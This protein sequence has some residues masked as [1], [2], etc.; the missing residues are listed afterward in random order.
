MENQ[1]TTSTVEEQLEALD[2][3]LAEKQKLRKTLLQQLAG[4]TVQ[5]YE[6]KGQEGTLKLSEMFGDGTELLL[7]HNMGKNCPYCTL[8]A[9]GFNGVAQHLDDRV[10][11]GVVSPNPPDV[12]KEFAESRG[13]KF[14][15][16]SAEGSTFSRD[17][18]F[19]IDHEGKPFQLPGVSAFVKN[20]DGT[21]MLTAQD[22]FGPGDTYSGIWHLLELLPKGPDGWHPKISYENH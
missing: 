4:R 11:F 15:M 1:E 18:G 10:A 13:W 2:K 19:E 17:L 6:L 14:P 22:F 16:Y 21:I 20:E 3:E 12:Q 9:D 5:D 7:V 8:W